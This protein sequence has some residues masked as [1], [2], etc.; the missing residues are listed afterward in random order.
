MPDVD[1]DGFALLDLVVVDHDGLQDDV[2]D[3]ACD[4][5][6]HDEVDS[7]DDQDELVDVVGDALPDVLAD[8]SMQLLKMICKICNVVFGHRDL[9]SKVNFCEKRDGQGSNVAFCLGRSC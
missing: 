7:D 2:D 1:F 6:C 9:N 5:V 8:M 3:S 4:E